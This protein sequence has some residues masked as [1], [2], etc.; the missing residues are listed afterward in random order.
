MKT[1]MIVRNEQLFAGYEKAKNNAD[2]IFRKVM[3]TEGEELQRWS[4]L[5]KRALQM[6]QRAFDRWMSFLVR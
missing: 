5:H 2:A 4:R 1:N 6:R 3:E